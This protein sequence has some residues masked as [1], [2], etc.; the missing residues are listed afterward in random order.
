MAYV[1][2]KLNNLTGSAGQSDTAAASGGG[3]VL[4]GAGGGANTQKDPYASTYQNPNKV[5]QANLGEN[6]GQ[7][8]TGTDKSITN[9]QNA[10]TKSSDAYNTGLQGVDSKYAYNGRQDLEN[11]GDSNTFSRLG[12]LINPETGKAELGG[13][14]SKSQY[15]NADA[16]GTAAASTVGGLTNQ[17]KDQYGTSTGGARLDAQLY[18]GSGQAGAAINQDIGHLKDFQTDKTQ[19]LGAEKANLDSKGQAIDQ[20]SAQLKND[21]STYQGELLGTAKSQAAADQAKYDANRAAALTG[22][23]GSLGNDR[24]QSELQKAIQEGLAGRAATKNFNTTK[25]SDI[26]GALQKSGIKESQANQLTADYRTDDGKGGSNVDFT[27]WLTDR[28]MED[29]GAG[30]SLSG[31]DANKFISGPQTFNEGAYL[32]PRYNQLSSLLGGNQIAN[33]GK[34]STDVTTND[35]A[36]QSAIQ[37]QLNPQTQA[38]KQAAAAFFNQGGGGGPGGGS[39][40]FNLINQLVGMPTSIAG[41]ALGGMFGGW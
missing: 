19:R 28:I 8:D 14:Q 17:L 31:L 6:M 27:Q 5:Y 13:V 25:L 2:K 26:S 12:G 32:D 20:R 16:S 4:A 40:S 11:I 39:N 3:E 38:A 21:G 37:A 41:G 36:L 1:F 24:V 30:A 23:S 9:T 18:R 15:L 22:V 29:Q 7:V 35:A 33:N 34:L 10:L